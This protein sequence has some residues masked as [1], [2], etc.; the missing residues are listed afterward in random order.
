MW[1][2]HKEYATEWQGVEYWH[3]SGL[4]SR[5]VKLLNIEYCT[6]DHIAPDLLASNPVVGNSN[7]LKRQSPVLR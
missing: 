3:K 2:F 1:F 5:L 4:D 7:D 6:G